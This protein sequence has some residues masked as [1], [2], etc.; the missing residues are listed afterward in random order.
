MTPI[1]T[2]ETALDFLQ[3]LE[4]HVHPHYHVGLI[5]SVMYKGQG[6]DLDIVIYP[7]NRSQTTEEQDIKEVTR[8]LTTFGLI[9]KQSYQDKRDKWN[10]YTSQGDTKIV[11]SWLWNGCK[12]DVFIMR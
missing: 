11:E 7:H 12:V 6:R 8:L 4:R 3:K 5:G 2:L 1:V 10:H 9:F